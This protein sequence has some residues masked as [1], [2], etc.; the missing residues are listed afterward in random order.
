MQ[1]VTAVE[2]IPV[3]RAV[4]GV[5]LWLFDWWGRGFVSCVCCV[6]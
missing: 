1:C 6:L 2:D 5:S 4:R 3:G